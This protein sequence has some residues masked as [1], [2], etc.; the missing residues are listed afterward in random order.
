MTDGPSTDTTRRSEMG[1]DSACC[2]SQQLGARRVCGDS[3]CWRFADMP[4]LGGRGAES[5][6]ADPRFGWNSDAAK[7][8]DIEN[9][10]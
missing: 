6:A 2:V 10:A 1:R 9:K 5:L 8:Y 3:Q 4:R 7:R